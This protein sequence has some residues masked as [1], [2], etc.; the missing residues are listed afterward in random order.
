MEDDYKPSKIYWHEALDRSH[1]ACDHFHEYVENHP[2]VSHDNGLK[3]AA[4]K[5]T[6]AM[7]DFYQSVGHKYHEFDLKTEAV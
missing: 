4:K 7:A 2:A 1:V 5:V 6:A 3:E